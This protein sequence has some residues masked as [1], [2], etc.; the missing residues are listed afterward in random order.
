ME[1]LEVLFVT[2]FLLINWFL[3]RSRCLV[4][5]IHLSFPDRE[6]T[7]YS[8][9]EWVKMEEKDSSNPL[10]CW[11]E[12]SFGSF[13]LTFVVWSLCFLSTVRLLEIKRRIWK[14][15]RQT[16]SRIFTA[17]DFPW[18]VKSLTRKSLELKLST[19]TVW[20]LLVFKNWWPVWR[21]KKRF[22]LVLL[23]DSHLKR[24][25]GGWQKE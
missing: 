23:R 17:L 12:F 3:I 10:F 9:L 19:V 15:R 20:C 6:C 11:W 1:K 24:S 16:R 13:V 8:L 4:S 7:I 18:P 5:L 21:W 14:E 25:W 22:L 2:P